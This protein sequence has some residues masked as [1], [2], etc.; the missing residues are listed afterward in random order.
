MHPPTTIKPPPLRQGPFL[1]QP[2]PRN[3]DGSECGDATDITY[4]SFGSDRDGT[5]DDPID[6]EHLG[7]ILVSFQDGKVDLFLDLEK[8]EA[9][10]ETK[11]VNPF[12][13][14]PIILPESFFPQNPSKDLP[15]LAVYETIDLGL[16]T[17]LT[18]ISADEN[19]EPLLDLLHG[20]HPVFLLDPL[21]NDM[22][23]IYHA[24]GV[25]ALDISPVLQT[26]TV[27]LECE[28]QPLLQKSLEKAAM[29]NVQPILSTFSVE[30]KFVICLFLRYSWLNLFLGARIPLLQLQSQTTST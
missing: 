12:P 14:C 21:H 3:L 22:V 23:Y 15:M 4:L 5:E 27:S 25:H 16:V 19:G 8:V 6:A 2:S 1:L 11:Q 20:N 13:S 18:Q 17:N 26:L 28:D 9:R 24:F 29:S 30:R 10:W 7:V